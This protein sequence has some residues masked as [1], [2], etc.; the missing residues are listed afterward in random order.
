[1]KKLMKYSLPAF[2]AC[3]LMAISYLQVYAVDN[4]TNQTLIITEVKSNSLTAGYCFFELYNNTD[5][6]INLKDYT[7]YYMYPSSVGQTWGV[8]TDLTLSPGKAMVFW[9]D[10][11]G[12]TVQDFNSYYGVN[13]EENKTLYKINYSGLHGDQ[14]RGFKIGKTYTN[15]VAQ[16]W[17]NETTPDTIVDVYDGAIQYKYPADG[18]ILETKVST[19]FTPSPGT[20][21]AYQV[22]K[23]DFSP[24]N[25]VKTPEISDIAAKTT[26]NTAD[27]ITITATVTDADK[28]FFY[29]RQKSTESYIRTAMQPTAG[30]NKYSV[31]VDK[32][33]LWADSFSWH[34]EAGNGPEMAVTEET[35][36]QVEYNTDISQ[37]PPL[38]ITEIVSSATDSNSTDT[39]KPSYT[40][41][42]VYN[43]SDKP[44]NLAYYNFYYMYP[45]SLGQT[46]SVPLPEMFIQPGKTMVGWLDNKGKTV[47]DFNKYYGVKLTENVDIFKIN[48]SGMHQTD[49]RGFKIG[50]TT[51]NT[52][53]QVTFNENGKDLYLTSN[54]NSIKYAYPKTDNYTCAKADTKTLATPGSAEAWQIPAGPVNFKGYDGVTD[55]GT[56]PIL[57]LAQPV[58]ASVQEGKE[59]NVE[60][61]CA[62]EVPIH[63]IIM[64]YKRNGDTG[65]NQIIDKSQRM[66]GKYFARVLANQLLGYD[67]VEF[68]VEAFSPFRHVTSEHYTVKI[69][70]INDTQ[71][72]VRLNVKNNELLSKTK[73]ITGNDGE[74]NTNTRLYVDENIVSTKNMLEDGAYISF[75]ADGINSYFKNAITADDDVLYYMAKWAGLFSRAVKVDNKYFVKNPDG[76]WGVTLSVWAGTTGSHDEIGTSV[77]ND[78]YTITG[79]KLYLPDGQYI[80]AD[81][82]DPNGKPITSSTVYKMGDSAGMFEKLDVHFTIPAGKMTAAGYELDT[83]K[84]PDGVHTI[85]AE[86]GGKINTVTVIVDNTKPLINLGIEDGALLKNSIT[87]NPVVTD[88]NGIDEKLSE[89]RLDEVL[90]KVPYT[91]PARELTPG[92]HILKAKYTDAA[93]NAVEETVSFKTEDFDPVV[94]NIKTDGKDADSATLYVQIQD[95]KGNSSAVDFLKGKLLTVENG[96]IT[97]RTGEGDYPLVTALDGKISTVTSQSGDL[98][99]QVYTLNTGELKDADTLEVNISATANYKSNIG[100]YAMNTVSNKWDMVS[101]TTGGAVS[102]RFSARDHIKDGKATLLVQGRSEK[103]YPLISGTNSSR[104]MAGSG[105]NW[106]GTGVPEKYDFSLAWT[107]DTQYYTESWPGHY[108]GMNQWIIEN[109]DKYNIQYTI[110]TGDLI[111]EWDMDYQWQVADKAMKKFDDANMRYGVLAGNHDVSAGNEEYDNY[112][113]YFGENRFSDKDYY[114][115][116]YKNNLGH[117][118]LLTVDGQDLIILYMS[119]DI[120]TEEIQWMNQVLAKYSDRKAIICLHRYI[121]Q[122]GE[123]DYTGQMV[124]QQVVAKNPN[125]FAVLN[126]HYHGAAIQVDGFDDNQD[127]IVDRNVYQICTDYQSAVEG[128]S[129]YIKMLYFDLNNNKVYMNSYS[130]YLNDFNYFDTPKLDSYAPGTNVTN[131]DI[132]ELDVDFDNLPKSLSVDNLK[133]GVYTENLIGRVDNPVSEA[134]TVWTGILSS[135]SNSWY[136]KITNDNGGMETTSLQTVTGAAITI[137]EIPPVYTVT[138]V[139]KAPELPDQVLAKYTDNTSAYVSVRWEAID[140]SQYSVPG[141]FK[142]Q[143][144]VD[145]TSASAIAVVT[146]KDPSA[147]LTEIQS[148]NVTTAVGTAPVL[149]QEVTA[150]FSDSSTCSLSVKWETIDPA[151]YAAEG[152][153]TV[154]G[155]VI[156]TTMPAIAVV[157]VKNAAPTITEIRQVRISTAVGTAPALPAQ[158]TAVYSDMTTSSISVSWEAI[159]PLKYSTAGSFTVRGSVSSTTMSAI[160]IVTVN[161]VQNTGGNNSPSPSTQT[162][163]ASTVPPV[164]TP[165]LVKI[166]KETI[167]INRD[168][169]KNGIV[170]AGVAEKDLITAVGNADS[171]IIRILIQASGEANEVRITVPVK[172]ILD[173]GSKVES[174]VIGTGNATVSIK[175]EILKDIDVTAASYIELR[176][177]KVDEAILPSE[178]RDNIG[179]SEVY[180]FVIMIDGKRVSN[181]KNDEISVELTYTLKPGE[182]PNKVVAYYINDSGRLESVKNSK[183]NSYNGIVSF[184]P[185]HFSRYTA[186]H[187]NITFLDLNSSGWARSSIE[188][189]AARGIIAGTGDNKF[190]P[191]KKV[192]RAE[193]LA[194]LMNAFDLVDNDA[195]C[196]FNDVNRQKWYYGSIATAQKLGIVQGRSNGSFGVNDE[197]SRQDMAVMVYKVAKLLN[198][199]MSESIGGQ[200]FG[201]A[202]E[203]SSYAADAIN[204]MYNNKIINGTGNGAFSPKSSTTRAQAAAVIYKVFTIAK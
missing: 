140:P 106:D 139:G 49:K 16:C 195:E 58:P 25:T 30:V 135:G 198:I 169:D 81:N 170:A 24:V 100:I 11:K 189:L 54:K 166:D 105:S 15:I 122:D 153:F 46:W 124:Q 42:E 172:P 196:T 174:L 103:S 7:I 112:W 64:Y 17:F 60:F 190:N 194:M 89:V 181:F 164:S 178:I 76:S 131:L 50:H 183:Y 126:G 98:P 132:Y 113:K 186:A 168:A 165:G 34:L 6:D 123:I 47:A 108:Y 130:P 157:T 150:V 149:P 79:L 90:I 136:A 80:E 69:D 28:V 93:G 197:I 22:P 3:L 75:T 110:H 160:A 96:G 95:S 73:T 138:T 70:R 67:S 4:P 63:T 177:A 56:T 13:L 182:D 116:S 85:R 111:D 128:G 8:S 78:D 146:V 156:S 199:N 19:Y 104:N 91:I 94:G 142:V 193:F 109:R 35:T 180:D 203:I 44:I 133:V 163:P 120:Y 40:F 152:A 92:I 151:K 51:S 167:I 179:R 114:G 129:Q 14:K 102:V 23:T 5:Q 125:V 134:Q 72:N 57:E 45:T 188:A 117:Y 175:T 71:S 21:A 62:D 127:G 97:V 143:G 192:T 33:T 41:I 118:D 9:L 148:V 99:Y 66:A 158:V 65:F 31:E 26:Y 145:T 147:A 185:E 48:Y 52:F 137:R 121:T 201:D 61:K 82:N 176:I 59:L 10:S 162:A 29:Y 115:G 155:S 173:S 32:T 55:K 200:K 141:E 68:Y 202:A 18:G 2:F 159:D 154:Q 187:A 119:W 38:L 101:S 83:S 1:M 37:S 74:G 39:T 88:T 20:V 43:N 84:L 107:T 144:A 204:T 191:N 86:S 87:I 27:Q 53:V 184:K 161:P 36:S 12:K 171:G 77:N